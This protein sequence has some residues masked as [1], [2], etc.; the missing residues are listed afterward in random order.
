MTP[1]YCTSV[2]E[3]NFL[4]QKSEN[5]CIKISNP[6]LSPLDL[7]LAFAKAKESFEMT[8]TSTSLP[9]AVLASHSSFLHSLLVGREEEEA[10]VILPDFAPSEVEEVVQV[11]PPLT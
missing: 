3:I 8:H 7:W 10:V 4:F 2:L 6:N 5:I 1:N 11:P 9:R